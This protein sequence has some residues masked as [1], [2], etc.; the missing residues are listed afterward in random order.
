MNTPTPR[1]LQRNVPRTLCLSFLQVFMLLM[2]VIVIFFESRGLA[3]SDVLLLQAWFAVLVGAL[4]VPSGYVADLLGRRGTMI[5]GGLFLGIGHTWL[6]FAH[7]FWPLA[8]FEASL[9]VAFSLISGADLAL[10][11]DTELALA[12]SGEHEQKRRGASPEPAQPR[13]ASTAPSP[14]SQALPPTGGPPQAVRRLFFARNL[15]EA[16]AA[17]LCSVLLLVVSMDGIAI[18]QAICGWLPFLLAFGLVEPPRKRL[19][20]RSHGRN[21]V[22]ILRALVLDNR[23]LR[24]TF[25][26]L[27]IWSLTTMY[28]VWLLQAHWRSQ[29]VELAHFGYIWGA[30]T[31]LS[32]V[33]GRYAASLENRLGTV[34]MLAFIGIGPVLGYIALGLTGMVAGV[35]LSSLFFLCRGFGLVILRDAL[36]RRIG[37]EIRAT[38][39]SLASFGFRTAFAITAP[40]VGGALDLWG[41]DTTLLLLAAASA[42]IFLSLILPLILAAGRSGAEPEGTVVASVAAPA[43]R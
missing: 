43:E 7:G 13:R 27:S 32:A 42:G 21:A 6:V 23:I 16:L 11:Y 20:T 5:V 38:A 29:G 8:A 4:E 40:L 26:A 9:A 12:E 37:S 36:N 18:A 30:L 25:L 33:A 10:L 19:D 35:G 41:L 3:L 34:A 22:L 14:R 15:S 1:Q 17:V 2:P 39:N 24:L 28:A 31:L